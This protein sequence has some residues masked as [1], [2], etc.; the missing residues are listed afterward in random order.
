MKTAQRVKDGL[1]S[2]HDQLLYILENL[3]ARPMA[4]SHYEP[5]LHIVQ[6]ILSYELEESIFTH[7]ELCIW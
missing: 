3:D 6:I 5:W 4:V 2:D 1:R 7:V